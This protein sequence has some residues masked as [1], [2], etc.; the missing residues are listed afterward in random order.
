MNCNLKKIFSDVFK[1]EEDKITENMKEGD[2]PEWDS[3][4]H[5]NLFMELERRFKLK[6]KLDEVSNNRSFLNIKKL[7]EE[8]GITC[9]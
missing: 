4:A 6:F 2:I 9:H 1:I 8:K 3:L 7:L 5:I